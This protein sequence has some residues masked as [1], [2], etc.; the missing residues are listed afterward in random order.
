ME[1][2]STNYQL[3]AG[4]ILA[5]F[6]KGFTSLNLSLTGWL[7]TPKMF[8]SLSTSFQHLRSLILH[9]CNLGSE[10]CKYL[11]QPLK[12]NKSI[13][14]LDLSNNMLVGLSRCRGEVS[15]ICD[16]SGLSSLLS[17]LLDSDTLE[18]LNLSGNNLGLI[19]HDLVPNSK[20]AKKSPAEPTVGSAH[21][22]GNAAKLLVGE[23][24]A[25]LLQN[26]LHENSSVSNL[27]LNA[28]KFDDNDEETA[29]L[30]LSHNSHHSARGISSG[31][32][33]SCSSKYVY[34]KNMSPHGSL[35]IIKRENDL[36]S[37]QIGMKRRRSNR[38][39]NSHTTSTDTFASTPS[40]HATSPS[41][42]C[43]DLQPT[44]NSIP[45][46]VLSGSPCK[47]LCGIKLRNSKPDHHNLKFSSFQPPVQDLVDLSNSCLDSITGRLLGEYGT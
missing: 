26:F 9:D 18:S 6:I 21:I 17:A 23:T 38:L 10:A 14:S 16:I 25:E 15:G 36:Y 8:A 40:I 3:D 30:L 20:K 29:V 27:N 31:S 39:S 28:N 12:V 42:A 11:A 46:F 24:V 19:R 41:I 35:S 4:D 45:A 7:M 34:N 33:S 44:S 1:T 13:V 22:S 43:S 32:C 5:S 47:S 37:G 2:L